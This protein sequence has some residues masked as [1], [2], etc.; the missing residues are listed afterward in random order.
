M[1]INM[2]SEKKTNSDDYFLKFLKKVSLLDILLK[3]KENSFEA[4]SIDILFISFD[5]QLQEKSFFNF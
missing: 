3:S 5:L 4:L 1:K 2:Q